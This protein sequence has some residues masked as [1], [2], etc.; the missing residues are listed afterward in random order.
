MGETYIVSGEEEIKYEGVFDAKEYYQMIVNWLDEHGYDINIK[1]NSEEVKED[2]R[3]S[4]VKLKAEKEVND[5]IKKVIK[6]GIKL[7]NIVDIDVNYKKKQHKLE[8]GNASLETMG[9]I[10]SDYEGKWK[11]SVLKWF[12]RSFIDKYLFKYPYENEKKELKE[13]IK[14]LKR[15]INSFFNM[16]QEIFMDV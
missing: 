11:D 7:G 8:K 4:L 5:Y 9:L 3:F 15:E 6:V 2:G 14:K 16:Q 13:D 12:I 1:V 10:E